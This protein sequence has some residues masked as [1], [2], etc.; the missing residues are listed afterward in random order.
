M[1]A[2]PGFT[3]TGKLQN[4]IGANVLGARVR[5]TLCNFGLADPCVPGTSVMAE[6][7]KVL[8]PDNTGAI[9]QLFWGNDQLSPSGTFYLA[10]IIDSK[11]NIVWAQNFQFFG[12][13]GDL[14]TLVPF[15]PAP[16]LPSGSRVV[17]VVSVAG[18]AVFDAAL[19]SIISTLFHIVL[20]E[21]ITFPNASFLNLV[22]GVP[23]QVVIE[24][25][26]T[27]N[28]DFQWPD[29]VGA[30]MY[31]VNPTP[32]SSTAQSFVGINGTSQLTGLSMMATG[33]GVYLP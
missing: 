16:P 30:P 33:P 25:N 29:N 32:S 11:Q 13:G 15:D 26:A 2:T 7:E 28:W 23:Y 31:P 27:G 6:I 12:G 8:A 17:E 5:V 21:N 22:P 24:Q 4:V 20:H 14:S 19:G 1:P 18:I 10:E 3:L 9:S